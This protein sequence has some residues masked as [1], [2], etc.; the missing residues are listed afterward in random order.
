[1]RQMKQNET[2]LA[3][4]VI[5]DSLWQKSIHLKALGISLGLEIT[6]KIQENN[7]TLFKLIKN[8]DLLIL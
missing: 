1:M 7:K 5:K 6:Y 2:R 8:L 4:S 3:L